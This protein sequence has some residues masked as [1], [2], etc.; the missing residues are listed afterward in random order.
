M[1]GESLLSDEVARQWV[2]KAVNQ[3][4]QRGEENTTG[5]VRKLVALTG[6][7]LPSREAVRKFLSRN[8]WLRRGEGIHSHWLTAG[9]K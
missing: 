3:L 6:E 4:W 1:S 5:K 7:T 8:G 9:E 2:L